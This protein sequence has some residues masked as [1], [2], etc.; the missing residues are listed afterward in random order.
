MESHGRPGEHHLKASYGGSGVIAR[1]SAA[2]GGK[3]EKG[4]SL[5]G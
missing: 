4:K 2:F 1:P 5:F 3:K